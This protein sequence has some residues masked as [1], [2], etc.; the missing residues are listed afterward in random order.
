MLL[1]PFETPDERRFRLFSAI[2]GCIALG[3]G[4]GHA[5]EPSWGWGLGGL[6]GAAIAAGGATVRGMRLHTRVIQGALAAAFA[7]VSVL[8]LAF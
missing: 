3:C 2:G 4:L 5:F 7:A 6:V 8:F 1:K